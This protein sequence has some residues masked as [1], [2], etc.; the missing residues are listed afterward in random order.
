MLRGGYVFRAQY[1]EL[2]SMRVPTGSVQHLCI[3]QIV[4]LIASRVTTHVRRRH[5]ILDNLMS[6]V[7]LDCINL[8]TPSKCFLSI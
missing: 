4:V 3:G 7:A 8:L 2:T 1:P 5:M 6:F